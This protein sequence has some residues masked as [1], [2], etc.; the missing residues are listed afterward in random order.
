[1]GGPFRVFFGK[2]IVIGLINQKD[3]YIGVRLC[4]IAT[5]AIQRNHNELIHE[6]H[7]R[8]F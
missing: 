2:I 4:S 6:P 7:C 8:R 5:H 3:L 1:M